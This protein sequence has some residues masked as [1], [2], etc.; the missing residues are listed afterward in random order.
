MYFRELPDPLFTSRLYMQFINSEG[1][2]KINTMHEN[3]DLL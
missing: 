3:Y 1:K 2:V